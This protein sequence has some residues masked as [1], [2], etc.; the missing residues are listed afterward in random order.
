M[1]YTD[2]EREY[3]RLQDDYNE[4]QKDYDNLLIVNDKLQS[5]YNDLDYDLSAMESRV[6][7]LVESKVVT[8]LYKMES[9]NNYYSEYSSV[10]ECGDL[11][12]HLTVDI[13][14]YYNHMSMSVTEIVETNVLGID[15]L[16]TFYS[17]TLTYNIQTWLKKINH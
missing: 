9:F 16:L 15:I 10:K 7:H 14:E 5:D 11:L 12:F 6:D 8:L 1:E 4:L 2:L 17:Y 13:E 3:D